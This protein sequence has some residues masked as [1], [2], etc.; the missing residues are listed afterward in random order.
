MLRSAV[1]VSLIP[2]SLISFS[3][4]EKKSGQAIVLTKEHIDA[5]LP[6]TQTP[7][8]QSEPS[9]NVEIREMADDAIEVEGYDETR[10]ARYES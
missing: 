3:G 4:C 6:N 1:I 2:M 7:N 8:P 5:A 9:P 10:D